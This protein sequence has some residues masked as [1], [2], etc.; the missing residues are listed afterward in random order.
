MSSTTRPCEIILTCEH[1]SATVPPGL[2]SVFAGQEELLHSHRGWDPGALEVYTAL[3]ALLPVGY[4]AAGAYTRL[5]IELNRSLGHSALFSSLAHTLPQAARENLIATIWHPFCDPV[6]AH[7]QAVLARTPLER[8]LHLSVHSF[9][10]VLAGKIRNAEIGLLYDPRRPAEKS[11][12]REW[13]QRLRVH[14]PSVRVRL[15]YPYKGISDGHTTRLRK[16]FGE[17][18]LG[19]EIELRQDWLAQNQP[20]SIARLLAQSLPGLASLLR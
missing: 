4:A 10:P 15:N 1:A 13:A 17:R 20:E 3:R 11:L 8:V 16:L 7:V 6:R 12:A 9:T 14:E 2:E 5:A 19:F 18:Y